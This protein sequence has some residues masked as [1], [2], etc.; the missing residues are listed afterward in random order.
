MPDRIGYTG[1]KL[2]PTCRFFPPASMSMRQITLRVFVLAIGC[3]VIAQRGLTEEPALVFERD[4]RPILKAHCFHCHG[5]NDTKEGALD[6]RLRRLMITGGESG[7][8][9]IPGDRSSLLLRRVE[10][11]EMPPGEK[12]PTADEIAKLRTWIEQGAKT[13]RDEPEQI[14]AGDYLTEEER[15]F[16]AFQPI[17]RPAVPKSDHADIQGAID[18][19]IVQ[20]VQQAGLQPSPLVDR[21]TLVRRATFDLW[22]LP[23]EPELV[24]QFVNDPHP[25]AYA[26]LINRL[27]ASTRYGERWGRHWLDVAGY[28]DSDGYT[29][30]DPEREFAYFYRDY[31]IDAFNEDKPFDQFVV[32]QLAGDELVAQEPDQGDLSPQT[33]AKLAATGFLRMAPDGTAGA[34]VDRAV[35]ANE[36]IAETINIVSTSL[37]G[38][39]VGCARCH[40]HRYDPIS[41]KDYY[42]LRAIFDPALDW[43][44]W[45]LP[46]QRQRSLYTA[47][48]RQERERIEQQAKEAEAARNE[49]QKAHLARTLEEELLV[50][51]DDRREAL[52]QAYET[53]K[54]NRTPEQVALMEEFPNIGNISPGSLYLYAEQ[55]ERRAKGIEQAAT[56]R[57]ARYMEQ[58]KAENREAITEAQQAEITRY[59]EMAK[60][61][62][63][64]DAKKELADELE[65]IKAIRATA[66]KENF[67]RVLS[68]PNNHLPETFVFVRG[69]H[70]Q[71]GAKVTPA[72]L[73]VLC[74]SDSQKIPEDD[75][76]LPTTGRRLAYARQL[77]NGQHPLLARV[78]VNRIWMHHFGRGIV[79]TAGDFGRLGGEPTHPEL[80]DWLAD[81]FVRSGWSV[82]HLQRLIMLSRTYQQTSVRT[83]QLDTVDPDNKLLARMP[84]RR[85]ESE[86]V[87]DAI[88][89][90]AGILL[91][92]LH[93]PPVPVKEDAVGQ[94]I[95][96][97]KCW[98]VNANQAVKKS[99]SPVRLDVAS[100]CK[101]AGVDR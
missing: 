30:Q 69:D 36:T 46:S 16:W 68:E 20:R 97:K 27:L 71:P 55:R 101:S 25:Q 99:D 61:C 64:S 84:V 78:I 14:P 39:T 93:G 2:A 89:S 17:V 87:R 56:E 53:P 81:E 22:G 95:L 6:L 66:P 31:V 43:K 59:R 29:D 18:A 80:L 7:T 79:P 94:I 47:A 49:R 33:I 11:G 85:L 51:P 63:E 23:P 67:L 70:Q 62:R 58:A 19:M 34:G 37:L 44:D 86:A 48:D 24:E 83:E 82:K 12:K 13:L 28:A 90:A 92:H 57:E 52:R 91:N 45:K 42:R 60:V 40:D 96:G 50:A 65:K 21:Y 5:E 75:P 15:S 98:M 77:T 8:A 100:M 72:E 3:W 88:L 4:V 10:A 26:R 32:E 76:Q 35:A 38:L 41:Q 9:V 74:R 54:A 1:A 73:T